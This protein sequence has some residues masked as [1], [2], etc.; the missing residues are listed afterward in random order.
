MLRLNHV[1]KWWVAVLAIGWCGL[2]LAAPKVLLIHTT[3]SLNDGPGIVNN[4]RSSLVAAG[5]DVTDLAGAETRITD[6]A[7]RLAAGPYDLVALVAVYMTP[8]QANVDDIRSAAMA[9]VFSGL[10]V[11]LDT[12][13]GCNPN[14]KGTML[15]GLVNPLAGS[16]YAADL[17]ARNSGTPSFA[18]N[19]TSAYSGSFAGLDPLRAG[20]YRPFTGVP[21]DFILYHTQSP[22][23]TTTATTAHH[24][25]IPGSI[26]NNGA[27]ACVIAASDG[28]QFSDVSYT[29]VNTSFGADLLAALGSDQSC[30][31]ARQ[32]LS[33]LAGSVF[34][35]TNGDGVQ[36][37]GEPALAGVQLQ[38]VCVAGDCMAGASPLSTVSAADGSYRFDPIGNG[39]WTL[40]ASVAGRTVTL[41]QAGTVNGAAMGTAAS[42]SVNGIV[43]N[44]SSGINYVFGLSVLATVPT[45][46]A[47]GLALLCA[48]LMLAFAATRG[49]RA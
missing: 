21:S 15:V 17:G 42:P 38:A 3:E 4:F 26:S 11:S 44:S 14:G 34:Q 25:I 16:A 47:W 37:P 35:D 22:A 28:S 7:T 40:T 33:S 10:Y 2:S 46:G 9:R 18:L 8:D 31:V 1:L 6:L 43:L 5:A 29:G 30:R 32:T 20:N 39:T 24:L 41:A 23:P 19:G 13:M 12:C 48:L 45:V 49:R 27:G 36:G